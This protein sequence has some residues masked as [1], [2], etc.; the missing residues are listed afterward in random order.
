M[1]TAINTIDFLKGGNA[2]FTVH[3]NEGDHITYKIRKPSEDKPYFVSLLSG[4]NNESDFTYVGIY[5]PNQKTVKLTAKSRVTAKAKSYKVLVWAISI[6]AKGKD[7]PEGYGIV[8]EGKCC[9]C[10]RKLT[11]PDSVKKGIGPECEK[12]GF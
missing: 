1:Q 4:P 7:M 9:R 8:H 11:T 5:N 12:A 6:L 10:G 3:N 2:T